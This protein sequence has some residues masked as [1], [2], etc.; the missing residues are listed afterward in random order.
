MTPEQKI[1]RDI[2]LEAIKHNDDLNWDDAI[3]AESVDE[4]YATVLI[5]NDAH[6][7]FESE[8][9][10]SGIE[11]DLPSQYSRHY[12][13]KEV[14][15]QLSDGTW[16]GWTYW[17]GGGKHGEPESIDWM[18]YAYELDCVEEE[19]YVVVRTFTKKEE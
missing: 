17:Y 10:R 5:D 12:E 2:L 9:R 8:F 15:R 14:A 3:T 6:W 13:S 4:A 1:K 11:T 7:D 19:R 16:V 18:E